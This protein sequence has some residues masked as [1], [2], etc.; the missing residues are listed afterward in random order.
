MPRAFRT[1][2]NQCPVHIRILTI[3][4][5]I[6]RVKGSGRFRTNT[7]CFLAV[8]FSVVVALLGISSFTNIH[9]S[10]FLPLFLS[11]RWTFY[12]ALVRKYF[13]DFGNLFLFLLNH[14]GFYCS[15]L[16]SYRF[17]TPQVHLG[18]YSAHEVW[19]TSSF[20]SSSTYSTSS[21]MFVTRIMR[22]FRSNC[23]WKVQN[24]T[25]LEAA[26]LCNESEALC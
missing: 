25:F 21:A 6:F 26:M 18:T 11:I 23:P 8:V 2:H 10:Y 24:R 3:F 16:R 22:L 1:F 19:F 12:T 15:W 7:F 4:T 14:L 5:R 17:L 13:R 20:C 9:R